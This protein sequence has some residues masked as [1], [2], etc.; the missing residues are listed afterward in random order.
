MKITS[1]LM[2]ILC[3]QLFFMCLTPIQAQ[4]ADEGQKFIVHEDMVKPSM[5][6]QYET[7]SK[8]VVEVLNE[9]GTA[10]TKYLTVSLDDM[11]YLFIS[12]IENMAALDSTPLLDVL[13]EALGEEGMETL[14][15]KF[16]GTYETHTNYILNLSHELSY[17]S[18]EIVEE[19]VYFRH[20]DYY[21]IDPDKDKEAKAISKEWKEL[22]TSKNIPQG[23][24]IY[25]GGLG[26]E[27]LIMVVQWATSANEFYAQQ[28]KTREILG[29]E[30]KELMDRTMAI[31][32]KLESHD[33]QIRPDL[34]YMPEAVM[35]EN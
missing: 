14:M 12:P 6:A 25:T 23:Y 11:R 29:E 33:G 26:T 32:R 28:A 9:H 5:I 17:N 30:A 10:D 21:F 27:P 34:S 18:G 4:E 8:A 22:Y 31:T 19:G 16:D 20:F 3:C 24:R 1:T 13:K 35:A 2:S 15:S 7:A